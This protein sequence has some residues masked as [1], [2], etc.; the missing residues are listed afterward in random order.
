MRINKLSDWR[1]YIKCNVQDI[2]NGGHGAYAKY[3]S[4]NSMI[5]FFDSGKRNPSVA[6]IIAHDEISKR[7]PF[8]RI[9]FFNQYYSSN[10]AWERREFEDTFAKLY[11]K[12]GDLRTQ[13]INAGRI[14]LDRVKPKA[15]KLKKFLIFT[16]L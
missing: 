12:T 7:G 11:P 4:E 5:Y 15:S 1:K 8:A 14:A 9:K 6:K 16:K 10:I 13:L 2:S 3:Y